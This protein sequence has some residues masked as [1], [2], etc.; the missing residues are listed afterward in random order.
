MTG[1]L[2]SSSRGFGG[3]S[4]FGRSAQS[5]APQAHKVTKMLGTAADQSNAVKRDT[6]PAATPLMVKSATAGETGKSWTNLHQ[7]VSNR[8]L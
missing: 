4:L 3:G 1:G 6:K 5:P 2:L 8:A 7:P